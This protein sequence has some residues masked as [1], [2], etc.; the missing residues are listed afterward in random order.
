MFPSLPLSLKN[1][2][3]ALSSNPSSIHLSRTS[4]TSIFSPWTKNDPGLS[5]SRYPEYG[6]TSIRSACMAIIF[7]SESESIYNTIIQQK[8]EAGFRIRGGVSKV[9]IRNEG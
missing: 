6:M 9:I 1:L 4:T 3:L 7:P 8:E 2:F 5:S